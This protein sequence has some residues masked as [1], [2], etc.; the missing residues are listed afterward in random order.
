MTEKELMEQ[1]MQEFV[2]EIQSNSSDEASA[3]FAGSN[4]KLKMV[5]EVIPASLQEL[6]QYEEILDQ[7]I[8]TVGP[9]LAKYLKQLQDFAIESRIKAYKAYVGAGMSS[10]EAV[11]LIQ[12]DIHNVS[13][14]LQGVLKK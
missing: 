13:M 11:S 3:K 14:A 10:A 9:M 7:V 2:K 12:T 4:P 8:D 1:L 5:K 6:K